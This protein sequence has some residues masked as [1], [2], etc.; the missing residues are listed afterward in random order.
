MDQTKARAAAEIKYTYSSVKFGSNANQ[1]GIEPV[2][3]LLNKRLPP[4]S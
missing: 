3:L 4:P 2:S 1:L